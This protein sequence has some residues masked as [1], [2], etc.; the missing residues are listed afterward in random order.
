MV[1]RK[2]SQDL[3]V[4]AVKSPNPANLL[5]MLKVPLLILDKRA[6]KATDLLMPRS[7]C[8]LLLLLPSSF[9][10]YLT[11]RLKDC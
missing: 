3:V 7:K 9:Q 11:T 6:T 4:A 2:E 10:F 8:F 1:I 5:Q